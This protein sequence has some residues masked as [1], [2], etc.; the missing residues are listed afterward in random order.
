[1]VAV[2]YAR[3]SDSKQTEQSIEGQLKVCHKYSEDNEYTVLREY[4]D[5]AQSGKTDDRIQFRKML[6]DSKKK[7][8]DIVI[9]YALDRFGRNLLQALNNER[10]LQDN[11]VTILSATEHTENTPSGKMQRNILMTFAQY[12]SD[13]LAQKVTRGL[14][15]NAAKGLSNGGTTPL[16][17]KIE[18]KRY[19]LDEETAPIVHEVFTKYANGVSM[20]EIC[21]SLNERQLKSAQGASFNKSSLHTM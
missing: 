13:E 4:I 19:V 14:K 15:I 3:Y 17:Y 10:S 11:G 20:K 6:E 5:R 8:F 21:D 2:I 7:Q 18:N 12:Y 9:V 1:M 16:G